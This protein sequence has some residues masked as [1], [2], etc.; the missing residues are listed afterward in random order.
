MLVLF[1]DDDE[2]IRRMFV[3]F[4]IAKGLRVIP[5][6]NGYEALE[7]AS[8]CAPE[9]I[10]L[11]ISMPGMDGREVLRRLR[12]DP[13]TADTP[14]VVVS[15]F[16]DQSYRKHV[17]ELGADEY[18]EKPFE[19]NGILQTL[20]SLVAKFRRDRAVRES[21]VRRRAGVASVN[22]QRTEKH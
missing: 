9:V 19:L 1:V 16:S 6:S 12:R 7:L 18:F 22:L 13:R 5:A 8:S 11:D 3:R 4:A 17:L 2:C 15:G 21:G 20:A 10:V 14:V